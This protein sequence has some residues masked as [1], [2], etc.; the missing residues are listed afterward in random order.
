MS[1]QEIKLLG[2]GLIDVNDFVLQH[3][4][5]YPELDNFLGFGEFDGHVGQDGDIKIEDENQGQKSPFG[6]KPHLELSEILLGVKEGRY[7]QGRLNVSRLHLE[8]A[9][10]NIHGLTQE[11]LI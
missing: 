9:T 8:E 10:I 3:R 2:E 5:Q 7:F 6:F 1:E 11:I 4:D